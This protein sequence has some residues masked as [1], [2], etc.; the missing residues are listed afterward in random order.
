MKKKL[1]NKNKPLFENANIRT[2]YKCNTY[3]KYSL[4]TQQRKVII[5]LSICK[6]K[7][8]TKIEKSHNTKTKIQFGA[9][10]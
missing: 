4:T 1:K 8:E 6:V 10:F 5:I 3:T 2:T 9:L 7:K